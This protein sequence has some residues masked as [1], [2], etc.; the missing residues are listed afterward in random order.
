MRFKR[1]N[2]M[3][4]TTKYALITLALILL[5]FSFSSLINNIQKNN[6][7]TVTKE[8][9][10]YTDKFNYDYKI[11]L[12]DNKYMTDTDVTNKN[13]AYVTDLINNID[14]YLN[15][16]Y[17][18]NKQSNLN[19]NYSVVGRMQVV[20][21]RD[22]EKQKIWDKEETLLNEKNNSNFGDNIKIN[23]HLVLDLR[24]K[25]E[26]LKDFKQQLGM[27][28]NAQF[29][30]LLK[31][32]VQTNIEGKD[33]IDE[34]VPVLS[35]DLA[36]KTTKISGE[37]NTQRTEYISKEF[38][39]TE[40]QRVVFIIL[41]IVLFVLSIIVLRYALMASVIVS[42]R[43]EFKYEL[44]RILKICQDKIVEVSTKPNDENRE[45]VLVKD[46]GELVKISEELFKP[47]LYY[48]KNDID[49]AWFT[50]VSEKTS[51]RYILRKEE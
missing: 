45:I 28:I 11:N 32:K 5:V 31:I 14:L 6:Q 33:V 17:L 30:V 35:V 20:Y 44:N 39:V 46:F 22:G 34:F 4:K 7:N 24:D 1:K 50:V 43:N 8:I 2:R 3:R 12:I 51:Y 21:S 25:N 41:D 15:Y 36:E 38:K 29:T 18:G 49:E 48:R 42:V 16:E 37:N 9:Y 26:L 23:E 13:L 47:I 40:S 19:Y 27:T 10:K